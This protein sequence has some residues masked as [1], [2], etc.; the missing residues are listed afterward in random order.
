MSAYPRQV[1]QSIFR[2]IARGQAASNVICAA[3]SM[4]LVLVDVGI[5]GDVT[6]ATG[7]GSSILVRHAKVGCL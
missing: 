4:R 5:D 1:T 6:N 7:N 2:A 3:N